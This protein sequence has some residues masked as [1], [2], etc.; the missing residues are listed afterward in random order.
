MVY[1]GAVCLCLLG[2]G[3]RGAA[4]PHLWSCWVH[5]GTFSSDCAEDDSDDGDNNNNK[6]SN[7]KCCRRYVSAFVLSSGAEI[8]G[9]TVMYVSNK[10]VQTPLSLGRSMMQ[11]VLFFHCYEHQ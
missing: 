3:Q 8:P 1:T 7:N 6:D 9:V 10:S 2:A 11:C 5:R 4:A